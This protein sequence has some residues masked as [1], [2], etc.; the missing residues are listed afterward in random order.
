MNQEKDLKYVKAACFGIGI[1][2]GL[3]VM[4]F[5]FDQSGAIAGGIGGLFGA[6]LGLIFFAIFLKIKG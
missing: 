5:V 2:I 6:M 4:R 1:M 3:S